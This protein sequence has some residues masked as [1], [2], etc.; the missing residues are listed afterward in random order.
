MRTTIVLLLL[1]CCIFSQ[2]A[3]NSNDTVNLAVENIT[4]Q[5][6]IVKVETKPLNNG[7]VD[8]KYKITGAVMMMLFA[9]VALGTTA[10]MNPK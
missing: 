1:T 10:S 7:K 5:P 9:A 3:V 2:D 6:E 8:S 4:S